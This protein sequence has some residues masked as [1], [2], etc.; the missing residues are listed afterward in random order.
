MKAQLGWLREHVALPESAAEVGRRL[1]SLGF[2]LDGLEGDGD[3]AVLEVDVGSNRGDALSHL[4]LARELAASLGRELRLPPSAPP[5]SGDDVASVASV[6]VEA[7]DLCPR[8][9]ARVVRGVSLR[10]SPSWMTSRLLACGIRPINVIVDVTNYVMLEL[11]MTRF[12]PTDVAIRNHAAGLRFLVLDEL[13]TYRGRQGADVAM[14]VRR[15]RERCNEQLLCIGTSATMA[16]EGDTAN[17]ARVVARVATRLFGVVVKPENVI[18]ETLE[19]VTS[20]A[21]PIDR[22][23][24]SAAIAAGV[25]IEKP[26]PVAAE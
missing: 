1:T 24:L 2:A 5:E 17:R 26:V 22:S 13:H 4:G 20:S 7:P 11:V 3:A 14:L 16:S 9:C 18:T 23:A 25:P 21:A 15:I 12:L 19:P 10:E 6:T 8:Y